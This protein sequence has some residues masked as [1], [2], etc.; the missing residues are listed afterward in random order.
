MKVLW[1]I[2]QLGW[3]ALRWSRALF[4]RVHPPTYVADAYRH[5]KDPKMTLE[6]VAQEISRTPKLPNFVDLGCVLGG[7]ETQLQGPILLPRR[8]TLRHL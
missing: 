8:Q 3:V 1:S 4:R 5:Q 6:L 2:I 7:K